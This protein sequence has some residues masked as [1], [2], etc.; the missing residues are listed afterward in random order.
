MGEIINRRRNIFI[1][2]E[3]YHRKNGDVNLQFPGDDYRT[4][5]L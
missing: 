2:S 4:W 1:N 3:Q 5:T